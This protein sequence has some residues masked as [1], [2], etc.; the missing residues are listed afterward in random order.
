MQQIEVLEV[1][2]AFKPPCLLKAWPP[3]CTVP[4]GEADYSVLTNLVQQ[5]EVFEVKFAFKPP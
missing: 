5:I 1:K 3:A 2:F 4:E